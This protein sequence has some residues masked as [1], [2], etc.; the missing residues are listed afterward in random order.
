MF[1]RDKLMRRTHHQ[2]RMD[3]GF[4]LAEESPAWNRDCENV[5][6]AD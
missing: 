5:K 3:A 2:K 4:S 1:L 6:T